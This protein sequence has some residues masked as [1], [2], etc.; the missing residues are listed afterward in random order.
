M[1]CSRHM[2]Q[3]FSISGTNRIKLQVH[4]ILR[5]DSLPYVRYRHVHRCNSTQ[6]MTCSGCTTLTDG[7]FIH[8]QLLRFMSEMLVFDTLG[9]HWLP[10]QR[11]P[12]IG[13]PVRSI[14]LFGV[15]NETPAAGVTGKL[16]SLP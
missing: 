8:S 2:Q 1:E 16:V 4:E 13:G 14:L 10:L 7:T 3:R 6:W 9:Q 5:R 12:I 15:N 11:H